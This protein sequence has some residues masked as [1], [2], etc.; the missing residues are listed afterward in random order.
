M[1]IGWKAFALASVFCSS[2][3][4]DECN[5]DWWKRNYVSDDV[6]IYSGKPEPGA[7]KSIVVEV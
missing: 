7:A 3:F 6:M 5:I 1:D 4:A 2:T